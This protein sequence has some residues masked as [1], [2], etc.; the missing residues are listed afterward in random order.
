LAKK[1]E[2]LARVRESLAVPDV[3]PG[4]AK[5]LRQHVAILEGVIAR[6]E[7]RAIC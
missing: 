4:I 1:R 3:R 5:E 7:R 6:M 2:G